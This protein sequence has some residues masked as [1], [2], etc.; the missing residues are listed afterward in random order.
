MKKDNRGFTLIELIVV[1]AI[2]GILF[3]VLIPRI[4]VAGDKAKEAGVKTDFRSYEMAVEQVMIEQSGLPRDGD[5][6]DINKSTLEINK[7]LD[8]EMILDANDDGSPINHTTKKLDPWDREYKYDFLK[9]DDRDDH[10]FVLYSYGK[11]GNEN[12]PGAKNDD[13]ALVVH[14]KD[15]ITKSCTFGLSNNIGKILVPDG[16]DFKELTSLQDLDNISGCKQ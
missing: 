5:E 12:P 14:Y 8:E 9:T 7:V 11:D 13:Y 15:G 6:I 2:I 1:I 10:L 3:V 16:N 4:N